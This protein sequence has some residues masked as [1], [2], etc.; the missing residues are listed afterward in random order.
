MQFLMLYTPAAKGP[1]DPAHVK[2]T[3]ALVEEQL[4]S[5]ALIASGALARRETGGLR[6]RLSKG[7]YEVTENPPGDSV[8]LAANGFALTEAPSKDI[9][10]ERA[11]QFLA[12]VGDGE[13]EIIQLAFPAMLAAK[14]AATAAGAAVRGGVAPYLQL[15]GAARAA[16]FYTR[17]FA[18]EEVARHPPDEQGRTMHIHLYI[19]GGSVMLS[20]PYP[21]HGHP[22]KPAQGYTLHLQVEDVD[23]A[24]R[25][26][27]DAGVEIV[28]PLQE[29]FWGDRY[30]QV[31]D[32][33]GVLWSMGAPAQ[34]A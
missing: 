2:S 15:D 21:E 10:I 5:G 24:W 30:G 31:R 1:P 3:G 4:K 29:M 13:S 25:R 11:K 18:A 28:L 20:D 8:L 32:P 6:I 19:N 22:H 17:A 12:T 7:A 26:A 34:K 14:H 23:A 33:F 9:L 16:D 27:V